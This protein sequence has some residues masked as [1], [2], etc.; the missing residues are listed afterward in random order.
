MNHQYFDKWSHN[1]SYHLGWIWADGSTGN[2]K[3]QA[4]CVTEDEEIIFSL[5]KSLD[6]HHKIIHKQGYFHKKGYWVKPYTQVSIYSK[7]MVA[8]LVNKHGIEPR[9]TYL[10]PDFPKIPKEFLAAFVRGYFDGDG[11]IFK[12]KKNKIRIA[13]IGTKK[14]VEGMQIAVYSETNLPIKKLSKNKKT[15]SP[16]AGWLWEINKKSEVMV[17]LKFIYSTE[18]LFLNKKKQSSDL[19]MAELCD[20]CRECGIENRNG[21]IRLRFLGKLLGDYKTMEECYFARNY[22]HL[23]KEGYEYPIPLPLN[24]ISEVRKHEIISLVDK[25]LAGHRISQRNTSGVTG[26]YQY[27]KKWKVKN[28]KTSWKTFSNFD[29]AVAFNT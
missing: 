27:G 6:S 28:G 21:R 2:E 17:F 3:L 14:F 18:G 20:Y 19:Y 8:C 25:R 29:E 5:V 11:S 15:K 24:E 4:G 9:K 7:H 22:A 23:K 12:D 16:N 10:N 13:T 26:V 1:M